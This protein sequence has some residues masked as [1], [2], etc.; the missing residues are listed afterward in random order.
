MNPCRKRKKHKKRHHHHRDPEEI[1]E[2]RAERFN[3]KRVYLQSCSKASG[4]PGSST[5]PF[6]IYLP[7]SVEVL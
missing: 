2:I 1:R 5:I 6:L 7:A 3:V 4:T